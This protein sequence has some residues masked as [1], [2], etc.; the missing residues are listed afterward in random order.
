[1]FANPH[2]AALIAEMDKAP[3]SEHWLEK[4][5][6]GTP[7]LI[8]PL[9]V[10]DRMR[11]L[12][13]FRRL[14]PLSLR[15][16]FLGAV[17]RVDERIIDALLSLSAEVSRGYVALIHHEGE[18][19]VIGVSRYKRFADERCE[20]A[21]AVAEGWQ[22]K[23]LGRLLLGHLIDTARR[24][25]LRTLCSTNLSTDYPIHGLYKQLGFTSVYLGQDF[26]HLVHEL[27]L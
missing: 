14:S 24:E 27:T 22:R 13:F 18:L 17:T 11:L 2:T 21:V 6:D 26:E 8:R 20:C 3:P 9:S 16:R 7:V 19:Q 23:G 12:V 1:M 5:R 25:G 4:L 15:F 10:E